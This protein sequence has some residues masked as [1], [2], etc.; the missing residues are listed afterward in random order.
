LIIEREQFYLDSIFFAK[1]RPNTYN[2]FK[3]A[4]SSLGFNHSDETKALISE[5]MS[6]KNHPMSGKTHSAETKA[7][8][9]KAL[10]GENHYNFG[11]THLSQIKAL[12]SQAKMGNKNP[13]KKNVFVY[14]FDQE[15]KETMLYKYFNTCSE[16]AKFF[17]CSNATISRN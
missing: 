6:G 4:G 2:I 8:I 7:K 5:A 15:T 14:S 13:S 11:K 1:D 3:V 9:S 12:M 17:N 16:T 10:S